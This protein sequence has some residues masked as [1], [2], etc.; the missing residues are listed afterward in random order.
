VGGYLDADAYFPQSRLLIE[1]ILI[2]SQLSQL[3][4]RQSHLL[5]KIQIVRLTGPVSAKRARMFFE[6]LAFESSFTFY[7][8]L[9][10]QT[11]CCQPSYNNRVS[12]M[13]L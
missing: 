12:S 3:T 6:V 1:S 4:D 8:K 13:D 10:L 5:V 7:A 9:G 11:F 2:E